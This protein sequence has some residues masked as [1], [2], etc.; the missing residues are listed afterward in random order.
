MREEEKVSFYRAQTARLGIT[1]ARAL[2][3]QPKPEL[4]ARGMER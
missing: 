2:A 1:A 3:G 4:G